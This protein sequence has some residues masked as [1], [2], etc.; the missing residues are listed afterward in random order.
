MNKNIE[1]ISEEELITRLCNGEESSYIFLMRKYGSRLNAIAKRYTK[2]DEDA[3]DC[4]QQTYIKVFSNIDKFEK[5]SSL[6][7]WMRTIIINISIQTIQLKHRSQEIPIS[8][9]LP[10]IDSEG[11]R[12]EPNWNFN[13]PVDSIIL[14]KENIEIIRKAI[15]TLPQDYRLVLL[16]RD[17]EGYSTEEVAD[18][19]EISI[20]ASK[21]R[22]HRARSAL[23]K[24]LEPLMRS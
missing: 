16:L 8:D 21:T 7:T 23:K 17:I 12:H 9:L 5:R 6:W 10:D 13:E 2:S 19:F 15:D 14:R 3:K 24:L 4:V 18:I 20:G 22:L 1:E 11:L